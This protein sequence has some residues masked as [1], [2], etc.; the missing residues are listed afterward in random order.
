[1]LMLEHPE[2]LHSVIHLIAAARLRQPDL[3]VEIASFLPTDRTVAAAAAD[4]NDASAS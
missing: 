4:T 2:S 1:M 3:S